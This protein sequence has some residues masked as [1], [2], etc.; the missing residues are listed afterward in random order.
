MTHMTNGRFGKMRERF[1][2]LMNDIQSSHPDFIYK[3]TYVETLGR[4]DTDR[5]FVRGFATL[6]Y[7]GKQ[8]GIY[9]AYGDL[10]STKT[11]TFQ[12]NDNVDSFGSSII[13]KT[14]TK[15]QLEKASHGLTK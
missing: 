14:Y 2:K 1:P 10:I 4:A 11:W 6:Y 5:S 3:T 8:V 9:D 12:L 13:S 7:E 15:E